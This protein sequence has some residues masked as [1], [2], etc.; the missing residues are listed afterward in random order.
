MRLK[1]LHIKNITTFISLPTREPLIIVH[2][3]DEETIG[4]G[5]H[6]AMESISSDIQDKVLS[7]EAQ[8][9][10][11]ENSYLSSSEQTESERI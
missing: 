6:Q 7:T 4:K 2:A 8:I 9:R 10:V 5:H 11:L 1:K 3:W